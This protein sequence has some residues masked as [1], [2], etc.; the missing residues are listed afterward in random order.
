MK[1]SA[2]QEIDFSKFAKYINLGV[3]LT[4]K[5]IYGRNPIFYLFINQ[6]NNIKKEDPISSLSYLLDSYNE[7]NKRE[8]LRQERSSR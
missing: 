8:K 5:D 6:S 4:Q 2:N 3:S 7:H 1:N